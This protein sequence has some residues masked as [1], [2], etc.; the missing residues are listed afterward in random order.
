MDLVWCWLGLPAALGLLS[1][2]CGV[3][4][5]SATGRRLPGTLLAPAGLAVVVVAAQAA[6]VSDVTAPLAVPLVLALAAGGLVLLGMRG[7]PRPDL[8][9]LAAA[10]AAYAAFALP[11]VASGEPTFAGYVKLDDTATWLAISDRVLEHGRDLDGLGPSTYEATLESYIGDGYPVG[12]FLP[13]ALASAL[14]DQDTAWLFQPLLAFLAALLALCL[15]EL[16]AGVVA[17]RAWRALAA[18]VAAQPAQLFAYSLWG[19]LKELAGAWLVA[20]VAV[21]LVPTVGNGIATARGRPLGTARPTWV[22][23]ARVLLPPAVAGATVL[24]VGSIAAAVWL[25]APLV[26]VT[27]LWSRLVGAGAAILRAGLLSALTLALSVPSLLTAKTFLSPGGRETL[28]SERELGNLLEPLSL[29]Q[30]LGIWPTGDFRFEPNQLTATH[31]LLAAL[32][33][34]TLGGLVIAVRRRALG[35]LILFAGAAVGFAAV[36]SFGSPWVDGKA[37]AIAAPAVLLLGMLAAASLW[38]ARRRVAAAVIG[39][40]IAGGV[41]WSNALA[42]HDA[43]LAPRDRLAELERIGELV[44]GEGPT[45]MTDYEPYGVRHFLRDAEPEGASEFRRREVTLRKGGGLGKLEYADIDDFELQAILTYRTLVLRRSPLGSRPPSIYSP[46]HRTRHYEVWQR[47]DVAGEAGADGGLPIEAQ[48]PGGGIV[49]H[50]PLGGG[51]DPAGVPRCREVVRL[52][53]TAGEDGTLA[54]VERPPVQVIDLEETIHPQSWRSYANDPRVLAPT[55]AGKLETTIDVP[56]PGRYGIWVG[57]AFRRTLDVILDGRRVSSSRHLLSHAEQLEPLVDVRLSRGSHR[58]ELHYGEANLHPGSD[59][60]P[61][62]LGPL[63]VSPVTAEL[64]ITYVQ[65]R[66]APSLCGRRL[67]WI[68]ALR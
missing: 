5:E 6:T 33:A 38:D 12:A 50:L 37:M 25:A 40:A 7:V 30:V 13:L 28:T 55:T 18:F 8:W 15:Y 65:P 27:V 66:R 53:Q 46:V 17:S 54:T 23:T 24:A 43:S 22:G 49:E 36:A 59:G 51:R 47:P 42:Y 9:P 3:L 2:G 58:L 29:L 31:L 4:L 64:A 62:P 45:L 34:A 56:E 48:T 67:D 44:A 1:L 11:T 20:L 68:E 19:G 41:L 61:L 10:A 26:V 39:A 52:A 16:L 32:A 60:E 14:I 21:L 35:P 57:G 63:V